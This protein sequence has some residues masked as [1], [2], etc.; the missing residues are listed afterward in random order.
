MVRTFS[1]QLSKS[2]FRIGMVA[3]YYAGM[4]GGTVALVGIADNGA[5]GSGCHVVKV[6]SYWIANGANRDVQVGH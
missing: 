5:G 3:R 6:G 4:G 2:M 1:M